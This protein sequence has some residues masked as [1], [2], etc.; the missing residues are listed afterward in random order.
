[1]PVTYQPN[2]ARPPAG[3]TPSRAE[4][5]LPDTGFVFCCFNAGHKITP[6]V[7]DVWM[8]L[9]QEIPGSLL[10][11]LESTAMLKA[12][13]GRKAAARGVE[14][15]RLIFAPRVKL[16]DHL[17]RHGLAD[18]FL[19]TL[20]FNAHTTASDAL[21]CG[22]PVLTARGNNFPGRVAASLNHAIGMDEMTVTSL[23]DYESLAL[24]LARDPSRLAAVKARL[25]AN[26][27]TS[28]LFDTQSFTRQLEAACQAL[29]ER[30]TA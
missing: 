12:N 28:A 22:L 9:L 15:A 19:D 7:F 8:R 14:P 13:L 21:W 24:K 11:L 18:L 17:A 6:P 5:G 27:D 4:A 2:T 30:R 10:W 26:R 20:P 16:P 25:S 23:A 1:M 3:P 29:W